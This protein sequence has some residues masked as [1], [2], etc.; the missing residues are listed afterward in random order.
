MPRPVYSSQ[1]VL[2]PILM[3]HRR[4]VLDV[5]L[6]KIGVNNRT[7]AAY[8]RHA[9]LWHRYSVALKMNDKCHLLYSSTPTAA[10][11]RCR[12]REICPCFLTKNARKSEVPTHLSRMNPRSSQPPS[13]PKA[14]ILEG[15]MAG[16][17]EWLPFCSFHSEQKRTKKRQPAFVVLVVDLAVSVCRRYYL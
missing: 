5:I 2:D 16:W 7:T 11:V 8:H 14:E 4:R 12:S 9:C 6:W 15:K 10:A 3:R 13:Q 1:L 17:I